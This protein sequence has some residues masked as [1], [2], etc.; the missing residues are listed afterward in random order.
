MTPRT[1]KNLS[2]VAFAALILPVC[3]LLPLLEALVAA[4]FRIPFPIQR[5]LILLVNRPGPWGILTVSAVSLVPMAIAGTLAVCLYRYLRPRDFSR[6]AADCAAR[7]GRFRTLAFLFVFLSI[8]NFATRP[9]LRPVM[10]ATARAI[11][12]YPSLETLKAELADCKTGADVHARF[13]EPMHRAERKKGQHIEDWDWTARMLHQGVFDGCNGFTIRVETE[14]DKL[15]SW[16]PTWLNHVPPDE[17]S[18]HI[19]GGQ[20]TPGE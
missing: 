19:V 5:T 10:D 18:R 3:N 8:F 9:V 15:L 1:S 6:V 2:I 12:Q 20:E 13:G 16:S 14:T 11:L 17:P 7:K 4:L